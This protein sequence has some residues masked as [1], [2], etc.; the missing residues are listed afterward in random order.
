MYMQTRRIQ[1]LPECQSRSRTLSEQYWLVPHNVHFRLVLTSASK[2]HMHIDISR[3]YY[4]DTI[5]FSKMSMQIKRK[6]NIATIFI[7]IQY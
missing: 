1:M 2:M 7:D 4:Q 6:E 3:T 5:S